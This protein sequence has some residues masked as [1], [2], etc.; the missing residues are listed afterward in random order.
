VSSNQVEEWRPIKG[1]DNYEVSNFG[2]VRSP[3]RLYRIVA[4]SYSKG[5]NRISLWKDGKMSSYF[6]HRLVLEAFIGL[7][8]KENNICHHKDEDKFNNRLDN[9]KWSNG[10][11]N[12]LASSKRNGEYYSNLKDGEIWLIRKLLLGVEKGVILRKDIAKMFKIKR[13]HLSLIERNI[14]WKHISV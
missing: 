3:K 1:F 2:R 7:P 8:T 9:L 12:R 11:K 6:V 10:S 4:G 13:P 5:Y 14:I